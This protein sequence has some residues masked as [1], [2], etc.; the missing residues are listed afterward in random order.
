M[1]CKM[2]KAHETAE[3]R[4]TYWNHLQKQG[5]TVLLKLTSASLLILAFFVSGLVSCGGEEPVITVEEEEVEVEVAEDVGEEEE[6][7]ENNIG[8]SEPKRIFRSID[9]VLPRQAAIFDGS[10]TYIET[11][12]D[13][14]DFDIEGHKPK[15]VEAWVYAEDFNGG[16]VFSVGGHSYTSHDFSLRTMGNTGRWRMQFW[17]A[18]VD[19]YYRSQDRWVHFALV[20]NGEDAILYANGKEVTRRKRD[21]ETSTDNPFQIGRWRGDVFDGKIA[22]VRIWNRALTPAEIE[23]NMTITL[24]GNEDGLVGYW[25]LNEKEGNTAAEMVQGYDGRFTETPERIAGIYLLPF[26]SDL[27]TTYEAEPYESIVLG[28]VELRDPTGVIEYQWYHDGTPIGGAT[29]NKLKIVDITIA[30]LG[31]YYAEVNDE[32]EITPVETTYINLPRWPTW[33]TDLKGARN[34]KPG[35]TITIGPAELSEPRGEI[36]FQWYLD[37]KP[38]EGAVYSTFTIENASEEDYGLYQ[39]K[40]SD[41]LRTKPVASSRILIYRCPRTK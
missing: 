30:D 32:R 22:E 34:V 10:E 1:R 11:D 26:K 19:F 5:V 7:E 4:V 23:A 15:T 17:G 13:A 35:D 33:S 16:G 25:P 38:I 37:K 36:S 18:D 28:P 9:D 24:E 6:E 3:C 12:A 39:V 20:Y 14:S 2:N 21:L 41:D 27:P 31:V 29:E 40:V 8:N